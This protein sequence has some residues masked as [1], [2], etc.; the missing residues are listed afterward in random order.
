MVDHRPPWRSATVVVN[1][2]I[3]AVA[4]VVGLFV[5]LVLVD[6]DRTDASAGAFGSTVEEAMPVADEAGALTSTW[7]CAAGGASEEEGTATAVVVANAGDEERRGSVS[8]RTGGGEAVVVPLTV[9]ASDSV[10]VDAAPSVAASTVSAVVEL[11][12]GEV[13]VEHSLRTRRGV[14]VAPCASAA[15]PT[16]YLANG[17][18]ARD[19]SQR[20]VLFNPF[21]NAAVVDIS[22]STSEG[23]DEPTA[24]QGLPVPG[25]S[26][27]VVELTEVVRRRDVTATA[28]VARRGRLVVDRVQ[29]FDGSGGRFGLS[30]ALA[31]PL[32]AETWTFAE[33]YYA[34][35]LT[36]RWHLFNPNEVEALAS[37]EIVPDDGDMPEPV[38]LTIPAFGQVTVEASEVARIGP[39]AGHSST[40]RSLDGVPIVAERS[41]DARP[42]SGREGWTSSLGSPLD[43][44][45]WLVAA[46]GTSEV[47]DEWLV[48]VNGGSEAVTFSVEALGGGERVPVPGLV[49]VE[50]GPADRR[51]FRL[52]DRIERSPLPL[53]VTATG[54][55]VVERQLYQIGPDVDGVSS[56]AAI[57]LPPG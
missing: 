9:P 26:T 5:A 11:D 17:V 13:G 51:A 34:A 35:G 37:I 39:N 49:D 4:V 48:V 24:L 10:T 32:P 27:R 56:V 33:G 18:T 30:L 54:P 3:P 7:F 40:V 43:A 57:P 28:V 23:R 50:L 55:V 16:W 38:D 42:P 8:W 22:F 44:D 15:S 31:A 46:G 52:R 29:S 14:D 53:V 19:A 45:R 36:E 12:G 6:R 47:Q 1:R 2:R 25:G 21:P 20:L 41:I